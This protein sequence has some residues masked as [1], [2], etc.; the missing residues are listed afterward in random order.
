[1]SD[2]RSKRLTIMLLFL[3]AIVAVVATP[4]AIGKSAGLHVFFKRMHLR[5]PI[6][7]DTQYL[8]N[9]A[10]A[11]VFQQEAPYLKEWIE[12][13][14][15]IGVQHFYL[16]NNQ[17][18]DD[19][20]TV[21]EPYIAKGDVEL[22]QWP[23]QPIDYLNWVRIQN[24]GLEYAI[25]L[26]NGKAKWLAIIDADEYIVPAH[27][28]N[29]SDFLKD[30]E[31]FGSVSINWQMYGTS[32]VALIPKDKLLIE[33]LIMKALQ[34]NKTNRHVKSIVRPETVAC[35]NNPHF[36]VHKFGYQQVD[37]N[38]KPLKGP[39]SSEPLIDKIR[40]NHYWARDEHYFYGVKLARQTVW[41][42]GGMHVNDNVLRELNAVPDETILH[43]VPGLK[44]QMGEPN[45]PPKL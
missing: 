43:F 21:L 45:A 32:N 30:Y 33:V 19:Y 35:C 5:D 2:R 11:T 17:S 42:Y 29:L 23:H 8:Y 4:F 31:P 37:A 12:Y 18:S 22:I 28:D 39:T 7:A 41:G 15:L 25:Q 16:L 38:K 1:M 6:Q 24:E 20:L 34:D 44:K 13:H 27:H 26:A 36:V 14:K 40:I 10:I 9:V 3:I